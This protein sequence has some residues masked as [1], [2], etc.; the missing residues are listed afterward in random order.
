MEVTVSWVVVVVVI[1]LLIIAGMV[2]LGIKLGRH[3]AASAVWQ[4]NAKEAIAEFDSQM[5][6]LEDML[7]ELEAKTAGTRRL[8]E[9]VIRD[10]GWEPT[11]GDG[12]LIEETDLADPDGA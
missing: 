1:D 3:F 7:S 10:T 9:H 5:T 12:T 4:A 8:V 11:V 2:L 6:E